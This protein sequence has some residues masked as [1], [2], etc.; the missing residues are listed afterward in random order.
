VISGLDKAA[1]LDDV[2]VFHAGTAAIDGRCVTGGGRV[3]G[4]TALGATVQQAI[5]Q[6]YRGVE[7]ITWTGVQYRRD[8]GNKALNRG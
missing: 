5:E 7:R 8:I 2:Y 3:L 4:V 6:A 1:E